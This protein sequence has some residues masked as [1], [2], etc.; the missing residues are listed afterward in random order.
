MGTRKQ[1][2][3]AMEG[4]RERKEKNGGN[5]KRCREKSRRQVRSPVVSRDD[6]VDAGAGLADVGHFLVVHLAQ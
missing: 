3:G 2:G 4:A 5:K 1:D 6:D